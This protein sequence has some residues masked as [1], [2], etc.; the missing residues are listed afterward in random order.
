M[1]VERFRS[2]ED[3]NAARVRSIPGDPFDRF[4]RL[5]ARLRGLAPRTT[6][7]GVFRFRTL[8]EAQA[9]RERAST[10]EG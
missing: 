7:R 9:A 1:S 10:I 4:L 2:I 8:E 5:C 3:M 6:L